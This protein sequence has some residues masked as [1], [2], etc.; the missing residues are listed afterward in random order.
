MSSA[1]SYDSYDSHPR[2]TFQRSNFSHVFRIEFVIFAPDAGHAH[3]MRVMHT[4]SPIRIPHTR[5]ILTREVMAYVRHRVRH[6]AR[7][8][9]HVDVHIPFDIQYES[10]TR[11]FIELRFTDTPRSL[12][13]DPEDTIRVVMIEDFIVHANAN[14]QL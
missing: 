11:G 8:L 2:P 12:H 10:P 9:A 1:S 3:G 4:S 6:I 14:G 13:A 7:H 5:R